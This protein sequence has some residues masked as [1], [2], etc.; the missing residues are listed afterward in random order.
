MARASASKVTFGNALAQKS[1]PGTQAASG[2][3]G[4]RTLH[5][6]CTGV[7]QICSGRCSLLPPTPDA[8]SIVSAKKFAPRRHF[9]KHGWQAVSPRGPKRHRRTQLG[10][11]QPKPAVSKGEQ[12]TGRQQHC[13]QTPLKHRILFPDRVAGERWVYD[14]GFGPKSPIK[15]GKHEHSKLH[16]QPQLTTR[17]NQHFLQIAYISTFPS[18]NEQS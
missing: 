1:T 15:S 13:T 5:Q 9:F 11:Q 6:G 10:V 12:L 8:G 14:T 16:E 2:T 7:M 4:Q 17:K 18:K 3:F